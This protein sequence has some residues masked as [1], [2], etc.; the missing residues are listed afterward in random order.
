MLL[1]RY[2]FIIVKWSSIPVVIDKH[3]KKGVNSFFYPRGRTTYN[4]IIIL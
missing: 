2:N 4:V 1:R 3:L